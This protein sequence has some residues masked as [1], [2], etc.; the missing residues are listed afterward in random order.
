RAIRRSDAP[1]RQSAEKTGPR[2]AGRAPRRRLR[3]RPEAGQRFDDGKG[4]RQQQGPDQS[5]TGISVVMMRLRAML[6][7]GM[8][9]LVVIIMMVAHV[10]YFNR[11]Q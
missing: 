7:A 2:Y 4:E 6:V 10:G 9:A 1:T 3:S 8:L 5:W 11:H